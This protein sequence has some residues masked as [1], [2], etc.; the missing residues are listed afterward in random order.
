[1][2][3]SFNIKHF[4]GLSDLTIEPIAEINLIAGA[5]NVGKTAVLEALWMH[6]APNVPDTALRVNR[7]RGLESIDPE[8]LFYELFS[9]FDTDSQIE[10]STQGDWGDN[11]RLL[12][13][14]LGDR[15]ISE[16]P[17][18]GVA[19]GPDYGGGASDSRESR[20]EIVLESTD[21]TGE[22]SISS[23]Y[24]V[25]TQIGPGVVQEGFRSERK[26]MGRRAQGVFL[27]AR[28][29]GGQQEAVKR[30]S[31]MIEKRRD[32]EVVDILRHID[33]RIQHLSILTRS[34]VPTIFADLGGP[35]LFPVALL[36]DGTL[37]LLSI[38]LAVAD[39]DGGMVLVDEIENGLYYQVMEQVWK[40][41]GE[42]AIASGVQLFAT[43]HSEECLRAAHRAFSK[44]DEYQFRFHRLD[45]V[46][47]E[48]RAVTYDQEML[49]TAIQSGL[50]AR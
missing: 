4:R 7:F 23:G 21:E 9:N 19:E 25:A 11:P 5:N 40:A 41:I 47:G 32:Q 34:D 48:T 20:R 28:Q 1:M 46:N 39:S 13:L 33:P 44:T 6:N 37:R 35:Q 14:H 43:T 30:L 36:G 24:Y 10:F 16:V 27:G 26:S 17:I 31:G 29:P 50:E 8:R 3:K 18:R 42:L 38:V 45:R 49:E 22:V 2:Y 12:R 15:V